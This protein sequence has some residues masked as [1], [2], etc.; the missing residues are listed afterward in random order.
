MHAKKMKLYNNIENTTNTENIENTA[1][2][3]NIE[4]T[5]NTDNI[6]KMVNNESSSYRSL[7]R[8]SSHRLV[9]I[10]SQW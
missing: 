7:V 2:T 5:A 8:C 4:N 1:N 3:E 6:V 10:G 9:C